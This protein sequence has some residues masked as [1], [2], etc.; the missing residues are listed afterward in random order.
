M[1]R[2]QQTT[3][4]AGLYVVDRLS[5]AQW[6]AACDAIARFMNWDPAFENVTLAPSADDFLL[7]NRRE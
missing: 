1:R 2:T 5:P 7:N 6:S 4:C 3:E